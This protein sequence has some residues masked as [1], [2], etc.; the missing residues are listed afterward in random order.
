MWYP[1]AFFYGYA[2]G[3]E[4]NSSGMMTELYDGYTKIEILYV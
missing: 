4:T 1:I 3:A 2:I